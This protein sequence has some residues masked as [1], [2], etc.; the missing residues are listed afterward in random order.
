MS[1]RGALAVFALAFLARAVNI[2]F[3]SAPAGEFFMDDSSGYWRE[4]GE[5]L[6]K[7]WFHWVGG[8]GST[9]LDRRPPLY[10][11]F[12]GLVRALFGASLTAAA[13]VQAVLDSM[14]CVVIALLGGLL[15]PRIGLVAGILA[16]LWP[17]LII[18]S[19]LI[20]SD[21][22]F[23]FLFTPLLYAGARF[24]MNGDWRWMLAA[25]LFFGFAVMTRNAIQ[26]LP[27]AILLVALAVPLR[28][29]RGWGAAIWAMLAF[30]IAAVPLPGA[31]LARN[32]VMFETP[33]LTAQ[34][35]NHL[36]NWVVPE[37]RFA[38]D[39]AMPNAT[40]AENAIK[41]EAY[42]KTRDLAQNRMSTFAIDKAMMAVARAELAR[43]PAGA[44]LE[45]WAM[46]MV[47]NLAAPPLISD[48]RMRALPK[49]SFTETAGATFSDRIM[50]FLF[51]GKGLYQTLVLAGLAFMAMAGILELWG[52]V[53]LLAGWP[54]IG[55]LAAGLVLYLLLVTGPVAAPKYRLAIEPV[56]IVLAALA[57]TD[58]A[59]RLGRRR[60]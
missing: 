32:A 60:I 18:H 14:T 13:T 35:G 45:A 37:V 26:F 1:A 11:Y 6:E 7:G 49:P 50:T 38:A 31:L 2:A 39:G 42:L 44:Y 4:A 58:F 8:D 10:M 54:W 55:A 56:L 23:L 20:V 47:T 22:L 15:R 41:F 52:F 57:L 17:N 21:T 46:G 40:R 34:A 59:R 3:L 48:A 43:L 9:L 27:P 16:A 28:Q 30:A 19:A 24:V 36:L 29:G 25:G 12:L 53:R 33:A 51:A 5:L